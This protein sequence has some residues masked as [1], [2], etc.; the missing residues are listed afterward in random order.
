MTVKVHISYIFGSL[1]LFLLFLKDFI[2]VL[3][4]LELFLAAVEQHFP[5]VN[6]NSWLVW[7]GDFQLRKDNITS[8]NIILMKIHFQSHEYLCDIKLDY[9]NVKTENK[10]WCK[11]APSVPQYH[12]EH[13]VAQTRGTK[14]QSSLEQ[15]IKAQDYDLSQDLPP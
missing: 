14:Q 4:L 5:E 6:K 12:H 13:S 9:E 7:G 3:V 11:C 8:I 10:Q 15:M 2:I 1:Q